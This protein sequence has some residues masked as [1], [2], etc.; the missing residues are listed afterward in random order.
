MKKLK[1]KGNHGTAVEGVTFTISFYKSKASKEHTVVEAYTRSKNPMWK[2][3]NL[4][5]S[6]CGLYDDPEEEAWAISGYS[7]TMSEQVK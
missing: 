4:L 1:F 6:C 3:D 5:V 7:S 2:D